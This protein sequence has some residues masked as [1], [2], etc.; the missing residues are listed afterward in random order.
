[1]EAAPA[2]T[3]KIFPLVEAAPALTGKIF[4]LAEAIEATEDIKRCPCGAMPAA[5]CDGTTATHIYPDRVVFTPCYRNLD[6]FRRELVG[7]RV[8]DRSPPGGDAVL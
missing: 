6:G 2:L 8:R 4:P 5:Q 7:D 3:G 1:M